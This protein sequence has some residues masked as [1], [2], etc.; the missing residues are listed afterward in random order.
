M[1]AF[2]VSEE[3][4]VFCV[5]SRVRYARDYNHFQLFA[6]RFYNQKVQAKST[7]DVIFSEIPDAEKFLE[8]GITNTVCPPQEA[9]GL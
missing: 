1:D 7:Q 8:Y 3:C 4:L 6:C 5:W 9:K 2:I